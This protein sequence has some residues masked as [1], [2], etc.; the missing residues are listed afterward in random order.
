MYRRRARS[1][2]LT[3]ALA[4]PL[5]LAGCSA[6]TAD[7]PETPGRE[8]IATGFY[9]LQ[10]VSERVAG[11]HA[12]VANVTAPGQEPHDVELSVQQTVEVARADLV[13]YERGFQPA[14]DDAVT[15]SAQGVVIDAADVVALRTASPGGELDAHFWLDP[16]L[17]GEMADP[18][19][20]ALAEL[21]PEHADV[22]ASNAESLRRDLARLDQDYRAGLAGCARDLVVV[23]HDAFGYL[24]RYGL[25]FEA[26]A[27]LSPDAEPTPSDLARL[28]RVIEE[29]G[30]TTVFGE[31][32]AS[33]ALVD[34]LAT[35]TGVT[36]AVLDPIEGLTDQT[37]N[38]D[39]LSLMQSNL[40]ALR[41]ANQCP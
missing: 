19:A 31:R 39:Y 21:D 40:A 24:S 12:V 30:I 3:V 11:D 23:S 32:L 27:G 38:E 8:R 41:R 33:A 16:L 4:A 5:A 26:I 36:T 34:T 17:L 35:D 37:E 2:C 10:F 9:P 13:V 28:Q 20:D 1:L 25:R 7:L 6:F 18:I 14:L 15:N 29:E 22:Y